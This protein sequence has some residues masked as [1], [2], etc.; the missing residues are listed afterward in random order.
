LSTR[1]IIKDLAQLDFSAD[2]TLFEQV[3]FLRDYL[4]RPLKTDD[5]RLM[6][7]IQSKKASISR[8]SRKNRL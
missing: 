2:A 4:G 6:A 3:R 8:H 5:R 7:R 1:W